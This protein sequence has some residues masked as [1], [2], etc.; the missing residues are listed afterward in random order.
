MIFDQQIEN[1]TVGKHHD[2]SGTGLFLRV[3]QNGGRFWVQ[4]IVIHGRRREMGLGGYPIVGLDD[5]RKIALENKKLAYS[6][7]DPLA[8]KK[9]D[10]LCEDIACAPKAISSKFDFVRDEYKQVCEAIDM[11]E[12]RKA[13]L[14]SEMSSLHK[15]A[16]DQ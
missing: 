11:A 8:R 9:E 16:I 3:D 2:G 13:E 1:L 15:M 10:K 7:G 14:L 12:K 6:G 5:A 4:R